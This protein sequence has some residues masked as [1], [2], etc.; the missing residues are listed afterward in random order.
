M[1]TQQSHDANDKTVFTVS[2]HKDAS[3]PF[4]Y[5]SSSATTNINVFLAMGIVCLC[6]LSCMSS[7]F[8][9]AKVI[10]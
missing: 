8:S 7:G 9:I 4:K 2:L 3:A 5:L 1:V 10:S 6:L